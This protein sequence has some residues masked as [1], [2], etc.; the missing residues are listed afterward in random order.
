MVISS[1]LLDKVN[2]YLD[3]QISFSELEEWLVP[4]EPSLLRE[5][6]SDDS[7]I[8]GAIELG[9][10]EMSAGIRSEEEVR[11]LISREV[12]EKTET[13]WVEVVKPETVLI[14]TGSSNVYFPVEDQSLAFGTFRQQ[15]AGT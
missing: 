10:A 7:D 4:R 13:K 12:R 14:V 8:I 6:E 1:D 11:D 5:S 15:P 9:L 2:Q 3:K